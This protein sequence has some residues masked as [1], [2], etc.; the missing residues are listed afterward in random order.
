MKVGFLRLRFGISEQTVAWDHPLEALLEDIEDEHADR[1]TEMLQ[2][3]RSLLR[4]YEEGAVKERAVLLDD[5]KGEVQEAL[6]DMD[7]ETSLDDQ[8]PFYEDATAQA[9]AV[10]DRS[11]LEEARRTLRQYMQLTFSVAAPRRKR[12]NMGHFFDQFYDERS[13]PLLQFYEDYYREHFKEHLEKVAAVRQGEEDSYDARNPFGIEAVAR[14]QEAR[15]QL[16]K[17]IEAEEGSDQKVIRLDLDALRE[18]IGGVGK[19]RGRPRS[20]SLFAQ[21]YER[22]GRQAGLIVP[23]GAYMPGYGKYFSRF[24]YLFEPEVTE[25]VRRTNREFSGGRVAEISGDSF[26]NANLHPS[27]LRTE[28]SYPTGEGGHAPKQLESTK[29]RV[30]IPDE[31]GR[32]LRI[33]EENT[34]EEVHPV[35]LGFLTPRSRPPLYRLLSQFTP[36]S[37]FRLPFPE[38][39]TNVVSGEE[40]PNVR[41]HPRIE[42]EG[43]LVVR[44]ETWSVS[45]EAF[46]ERREQESKPAYF[47][48]VNN[49][50]R[51][52]GIPSE[53]YVRLRPITED[54]EWEN[55]VSEEETPEVGEVPAD[56][57]AGQQENRTRRSRDYRKPQYIDF[58]NP[59]L[60]N[61]FGKLAVNLESYEARLIE[62][63]PRQSDLPE[64]N[65]KK[66][67]EELMMQVD[68]P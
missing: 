7:I 40:K 23:R 26:F 66:Y 33:W 9:K 32:E 54:K 60:A 58:E 30:G 62:R 44:R 21:P 36:T 27:L 65:G 53:V 17:K 50:R 35:D 52:R 29:L 3:V 37:S 49:W 43:G 67:T 46:P 16:Q 56:G 5:I 68:F 18:A 34:G 51:K 57:E 15:S 19:E 39:Q 13:V 25:A 10:V 11:R 45:E 22:E 12:L 20:V 14:I 64:A 48:R 55:G 42:I 47:E 31:A 38:D 2:T 61:L 1:T 59:L 41:H 24:L 6:E 4:K 8:L 63:F 28:I